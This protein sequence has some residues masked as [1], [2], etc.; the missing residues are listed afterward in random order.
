MSVSRSTTV[1]QAAI[2]MTEENVS[3]LLV[4]DSEKGQDASYGSVVG[5]VTD[6]DIRSR[7][8]AKGLSTDIAVADIMSTD[9]IYVQSNQFVFDAM[10]LMLKH[11][12]Q[13]L[14]I[15]KKSGILV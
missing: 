8:V 12:V 7:L 11:N 2:R 15:L 10:M 9:L 1:H 4:I 14:P 13:H 3:S 6:L 5:I